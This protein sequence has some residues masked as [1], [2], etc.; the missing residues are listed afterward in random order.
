MKVVL[1][2]PIYQGGKIPTDF[3]PAFKMTGN[4]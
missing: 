4:S 3:S 1:L 2:K